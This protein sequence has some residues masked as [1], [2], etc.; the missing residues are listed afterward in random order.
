MKMTVIPVI[1]GLPGKG[2]IRG[3]KEMEIGG[4]AETIETTGLQ[5]SRRVPGVLR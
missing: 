2:F 4:G 5:I 1:T 3:R